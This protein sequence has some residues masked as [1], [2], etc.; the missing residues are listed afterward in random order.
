METDFLIQRTIRE[1]FKDC[2]VITIAH[3]LHTIS[4]YDRVMVMDAGKVCQINSCSSA[5]K[6]DMLILFLAQLYFSFSLG[7]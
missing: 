3:R 5:F 4:S 7:H 2:T 6:H 1:A